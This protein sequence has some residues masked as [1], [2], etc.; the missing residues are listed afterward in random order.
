MSISPEKEFEKN[1]R[2]Q[3]QISKAIANRQKI[4]PFGASI[5]QVLEQLEPKHRQIRHL[6]VNLDDILGIDAQGHYRIEHFNSWTA[7]IVVDTPVWMY[8]IQCR[9]NGILTKFKNTNGCKRIKNIKIELGQ[10]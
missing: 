2:W 3:Q 8:Q 4:K 7:K 10:V 1:A 6:K 9:K 5:A